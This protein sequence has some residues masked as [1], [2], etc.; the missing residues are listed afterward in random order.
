VLLYASGHDRRRFVAALSSVLS[1]LAPLPVGFFGWPYVGEHSEQQQIIDPFERTGDHQ[2]PAEG[3][4][5]Q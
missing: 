3:R 1:R 2:G 5:T 4:Q